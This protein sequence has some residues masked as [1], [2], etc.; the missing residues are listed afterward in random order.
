[1]DV[2]R[3]TCPTARTCCNYAAP[4]V[5]DVPCHP[6]PGIVHL[7]RRT[8][9][10]PPACDTNRY[11]KSLSASGYLNRRSE[12]T[13][14]GSRLRALALSPCRNPSLEFLPQDSSLPLP[15]SRW[16]GRSSRK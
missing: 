7:R 5:V 8:A 16:R 13:A 3:D 11:K 6:C 9:L 2:S 15:H 1:M 10:A 4:A 14:H 12:S